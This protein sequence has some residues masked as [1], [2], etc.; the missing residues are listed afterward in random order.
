MIPVLLPIV[1]SGP[2]T[3]V[4]GVVLIILLVGI[5]LFWSLTVE[6]TSERLAVWFGPGVIHKVFRVDDIRN[7]QIAR[8]P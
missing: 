5:F 4:A 6:V 3:T 1:Q 2:G 7:V 8:N